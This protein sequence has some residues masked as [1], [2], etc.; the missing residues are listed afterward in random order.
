MFIIEYRKNRTILKKKIFICQPA[1]D[2]PYDDFHVFIFLSM[3]LFLL[4]QC[5]FTIIFPFQIK[6]HKHHTL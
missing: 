5:D 3:Y 4:V 6:F 1:K 2:N